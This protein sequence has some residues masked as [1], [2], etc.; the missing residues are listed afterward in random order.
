MIVLGLTCILGL[1]RAVL[2]E[3]TAVRDF[4]VCHSKST[5]P[6]YQFYTCKWC[7]VNQDEIPWNVDT[8]QTVNSLD[9]RPKYRMGL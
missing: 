5:I 1:F 9:R 2:H 6:I 4:G 8:S 3:L 7:R